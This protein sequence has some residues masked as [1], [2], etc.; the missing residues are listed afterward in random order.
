MYYPNFTIENY[1]LFFQATIQEIQS[2]N[3]LLKLLTGSL[4]TSHKIAITS[5]A[6]GLLSGETIINNTYSYHEI[7]VT[8]LELIEFLLQDGGLYLSWHRCREI[9]D[10]LMLD[11][12]NC[13]EDYEVCE[14]YT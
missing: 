11:T 7:I 10:C 12:T 13:D 1:V 2:E 3:A 4:V 6:T 9:W 8:H 5:T 14:F